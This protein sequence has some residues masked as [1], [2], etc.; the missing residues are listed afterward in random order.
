M[1]KA[2]WRAGIL[3]AMI[4]FFMTGA[5]FAQSAADVADAAKSAPGTPA[6]DRFLDKLPSIK[7][8]DKFGNE[9]RYHI[10]EGDILATPQQVF[11]WASEHSDSGSSARA[12][13]SELI[14][15]A[16]NGK[17]IFWPPGQRTLTYSVERSTFDS[18]DAYTEVVTKFEQAT[19]DW[20]SKCRSC[21]LTFKRVEPATVDPPLF[22]VIFD[23]NVTDFIAAAFFPNDPEDKRFVVVG[24]Q[25]L[26]TTFDRVGVFRHEIGHILGY[27]HNH[28]LG[29]P[30]CSRESGSWL[31]L[32]PDEG[33]DSL[34]VMHY[35]CGG[36]GT[37]ELKISATDEQGH[38]KLYGP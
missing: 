20:E 37:R 28:I 14:V 2:T 5:V 8:K 7:T 32:T 24:P 26:T 6:F 1:S 29:V 16:V 19:R 30:G 12:A 4:V 21:G 23:R 38:Q 10:I 33:R 36:G 15:L 13:N 3:G 35:F 27:R 17:M 31:P 34:S 11:N 9:R 25:Y 18:E 22:K